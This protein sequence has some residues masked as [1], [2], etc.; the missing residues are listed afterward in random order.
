MAFGGGG[1]SGVGVD[2]SSGLDDLQAQ[3]MAAEISE[4]PPVPL[5]ETGCRCPRNAIAVVR[6][7]TKVNIGCVSDDKEPQDRT[8][9]GGTDVTIYDR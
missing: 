9:R 6:I 2:S 5:E 4:L 3:D 8:G 1:G 7:V